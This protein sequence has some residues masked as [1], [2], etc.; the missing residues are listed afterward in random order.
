MSKKPLQQKVEDRL[1]SLIPDENAPAEVKIE[2][3]KTLE[4]LKHIKETT[5]EYAP[6]MAKEEDDPKA[7]DLGLFGDTEQ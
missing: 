3:K 4:A 7:A 6:I 2:V 5:E 1:Q